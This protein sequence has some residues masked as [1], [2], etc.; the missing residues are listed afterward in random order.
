MKKKISSCGTFVLVLGGLSLACSLLPVSATLQEATST[1]SSSP[2]G[3]TPTSPSDVRLKSF[4]DYPSIP[5]NLPASFSGGYSLPVDLSQVTGADSAALTAS[6]KD[7]LSK[8]GFVVSPPEPGKFQE[9]FQLYESLRYEENQPV[10]VTTDAVY[11]IYHLIFDKMLRDLERENFTSTLKTLTSSL[12]AASHAQFQ[13]VQGSALE[14]PAR[15]NV[16]FFAVAAQLLGLPDEVP[17][18]ASDL[19]SAEITLIMAH[20]GFSI[21]PIWDRPDLPDDQKYR[22]DYSQYV[23][24]GHYTKSEDLQR[25]FRAMMWYGRMTFRLRDSFETQRALLATQALRTTTAPDGTP[26][27]QLWQNIYEPTVFIVGKADD[28]SFTEYGALSDSV[29]GAGAPISAF[30]DQGKIA[31]FLTAAKSLPPPQINSMW[32]WIWED[33][34]DATKGFRLMGQRFTLDEYVFG[35][36][37]WRNVGTQENPRGLPKALD[38]FAALGS[39]EALS[40]LRT[41][42]EDQFKNFD[43]QITKVQSEISSLQKDTWTQN[44]Y[45]SWLYSFQPLISVKDNRFPPFMQNPAWVRK[46]LH[47]ALASWTELKHD[48]ILYAKQVMAEM[49]GGGPPAPP[50][51][52]V[53][54]NPEAYARLRALAMMTKSGL[55]SRNLLSATTG[56]NLDNLIDLLAF[57]Q[58]ISEKELAGQSITDEEY[59]RIQ[60]FGGELESLTVAAADRDAQSASYKDLSDQKAA[61][62]ADVATGITKDGAPVVLEEGVGQP[63]FIFVVLPDSPWRLGIGAVFTY[64]E[65][66]VAPGDRMTDETWQALVSGSTPPAPPEWT[67]SFI[68][69]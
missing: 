61:L 2:A 20:S 52:Y 23:P 11:H 8:S 56:G 19:T 30:V 32:V 10:F 13:Q 65:F 18:E 46:D 38:F 28:L 42:G 7:A 5:V 36:M 67:S 34:T 40:I 57:L 9:F 50:H 41:Q 69:P 53:E 6:Q 12:L 66:T 14:D 68:V 27:V 49:G 47:T 4:A 3:P 25:Y 24:R 26:A 1:P 31:E 54:P 58:S 35:Q 29:F 37:I 43:S 15:R 17:S 51:G 60:Y 39:E 45:Y 21:S 62:V 22:E 48:T 55:A 16:A 33:K 63:T 64:Y 59:L 44:L